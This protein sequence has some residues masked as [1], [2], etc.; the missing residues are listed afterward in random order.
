MLKAC[1]TAVVLAAIAAPAAIAGSINLQPGFYQIRT[2][3]NINGVENA[4]TAS[5]CMTSTDASRS[6]QEVG[7]ATAAGLGCTANL[8]DE[9]ETSAQFQ[10]A[11]PA[12]AN[13]TGGTLGVSTNSSASFMIQGDFS[14]RNPSGGSNLSVAMNVA[15]QR[16]GDC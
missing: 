1:T 2:T 16:V 7:T 14:A 3:L 11:C 8:L 4:N 6:F 9:T 5:Q 13:F 15:S 12:S 10:L